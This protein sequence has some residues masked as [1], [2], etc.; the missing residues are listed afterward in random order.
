[1]QQA[2]RPQPKNIVIVRNAYEWQYGGAE[3]F[4][5]N[6]ATALKHEHINSVVV[7]RVPELLKHC[8]RAGL[9]TFRNIWLKN[10]THRRWMPVY[11]LLFPLLVSQYAWLLLRNRADLLIATSRDD[12]IFGTMAAKLLGVPVVWFDH[13]DMKHTVAQPFRFLSRSYYWSLTH[14]DRVI[15]TSHA[16]YQKIDKNLDRSLQSNFVTINNGALRGG[17][18]PLER[19]ADTQIIA[20]AGRLDRDKGIFDLVAAAK[21]LQ[22]TTPGVQFWLAG[23]GPDEDELKRLIAEA[24]VEGS[25]RLLGHMDNVWDLLLAADVFVYPTYHDAA[26]LAPIEALLAGVPV[27]ASYIGGIPEAIPSTAGI[28]LPPH[29]P[30]RWASELHALLSDK[31]RLARYREGAQAAGHELDFTT[32]LKDKYLPLFSEIME[33]K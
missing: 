21:K 16:E 25:F 12:Q 4:A 31:K 3:Q 11:Y 1:M 15:M 28:L 24:K 5:Y 13:A 6:L 29:D 32:V 8:Q 9:K 18:T 23:K 17:G 26:P 33:K 27:V 20:Y 19:P 10:E 7:T 2:A 30:D 22:K 14:A